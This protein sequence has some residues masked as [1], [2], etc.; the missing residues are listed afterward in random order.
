MSAFTTKYQQ[1]MQVSLKDDYVVAAIVWLPYEPNMSR[2]NNMYII[3]NN[4]DKCL[5]VCLFEL[6][7]NV[8]FV[9]FFIRF[10]HFVNALFVDLLPFF[11][12]FFFFEK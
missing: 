1:S 12:F 10:E 8:N 9:H 2:L 4:T 11:F 6:N 5:F 3:S 7:I